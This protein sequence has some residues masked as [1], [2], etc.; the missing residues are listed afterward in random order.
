MIVRHRAPGDKEGTTLRVPRGSGEQVQALLETQYDPKPLSKTELR[1]AARA[2]R[3]ELRPLGR[4]ASRGTHVVRRGET[5]S[6]IGARY[7]KSA[8]R[9]AQMNGLS[10]TGHIRA[11]QRLRVR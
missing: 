11:G 9:L 2:H 6:Q 7:G 1:T 5:L 3:L 8:T 10:S 4:R